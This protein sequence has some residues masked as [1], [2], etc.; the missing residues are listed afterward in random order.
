MKRILLALVGLL[1]LLV[2]LGFIM[3]AVAWWQ[4][5]GI[6]LGAVLLPLGLGGVL[7]AGSV[8]AFVKSACRSN[9]K[10]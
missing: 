7:L 3:P 2:G 1:A 9:A 4:A 6:A 8:F 10:N 5:R